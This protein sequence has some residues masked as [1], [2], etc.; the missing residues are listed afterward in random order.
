MET[1]P[2]TEALNAVLAPVIHA[3]AAAAPCTLW[4]SLAVVAAIIVVALKQ[5]VKAKPASPN[6]PVTAPGKW[7]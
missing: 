7:A 2:I 1:S 3:C 6:A 4:A 5:G